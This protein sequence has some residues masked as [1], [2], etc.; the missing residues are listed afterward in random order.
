MSHLMRSCDHNYTPD[1]KINKFKIGHLYLRKANFSEIIW[2]NHIDRV[3]KEGLLQKCGINF[4]LRKKFFNILR[5]SN[6]LGN[7]VL[8]VSPRQKEEEVELYF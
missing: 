6:M 1:R 4:V 3:V 7:S 5:S 8:A 2:E